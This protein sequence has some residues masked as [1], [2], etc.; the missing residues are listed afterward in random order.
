MK[1][2]LQ[3]TCKRILAALIV[4]ALI[5]VSVVFV[6]LDS[7]AFSSEISW[8]AAYQKMYFYIAPYEGLTVQEA[9]PV[10]GGI[11][12]QHMRVNIN[13]DL[14]EKGASD[15]LS[16]SDKLVGGKTYHYVITVEKSDSGT[17]YPGY[18]EPIFYNASDYKEADFVS[19]LSTQNIDNGKILKVECDVTVSKKP[20]FNK[21]ACYVNFAKEGG[22]ISNKDERC[23]WII[24]HYFDDSKC[25]WKYYEDGNKHIYQYDIDGDGNNDIDLTYEE[26][27]DGYN[28]SMRPSKSTNITG[29]YTYNMT[30]DY[31]KSNETNL[32]YYYDKV[33]F[34]FS[35]SDAG[36]S[37]GS[38]T[39]SS[40][41]N[42]SNNNTSN[43][44]SE[45]AGSSNNQN[46]KT[47]SN[48]SNSTGA[49]NSNNS[50]GSNNTTGSNGS[51]DNQ[52]G[53][54]TYENEWVNGQWYG[55]NGDTSYTAQGSWKSDGSG[56]WFEDST[57]WYPVSQ[58]QKIDGSWYYFNA[59]GYMASSEWRDGYYLSGS[60][61]LD[62]APTASWYSDS[63]GW[64]FMDTS[65][66]YPYSQWQKINGSW[67]YFDG[68]GYMV[69][70]RYIEGYWI[71]A[72][73]VC[74]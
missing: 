9:F 12:D 30:E 25:Y 71:G 68:S 65:G 57:G 39:N 52:S 53:A 15:S 63:Y 58:W 17:S 20:S 44:N 62:Y 40:S 13:G 72:D 14:Y 34:D 8:D 26:L 41:N 19:N 55:A 28:A 3:R 18:F 10:S 36:S 21:G 22:S 66:W 43:N 33:I 73:G 70:S 64:Y 51:S 46:N 49:T 59:N 74:N 61:A 7:N 54:V 42:T 37:S 60:G 69:T 31:K 29:Q 5:A 45:N 32:K 4:A 1:N 23:E 50:L 11:A 27:S 47:G 56:W 35:K 2:K 6:P 48:A 67:Y 24:Y 38:Q 16:Y